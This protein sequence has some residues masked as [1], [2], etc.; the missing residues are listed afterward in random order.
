[1]R[2]SENGLFGTIIVADEH[3][4]RSVLLKNVREGCSFLDPSASIVSSELVGPGPI[5]GCAY[6]LSWLVPGLLFPTGSGLMIGL[7]AGA[8]AV[9]LL[10]N[11][12]DLDLTVVE[13]D[14][15][16]IQVAVTYFPLV[17]YYQNIGRLKIVQSDAASYVT[18]CVDKFDF[19]CADAY[20]GEQSMVD[21]FLPGMCKLCNSIYVNY[22]GALNDLQLSKTVEVM[23]DAQLQPEDLFCTSKLHVESPDVN[24]NWCIASHCPS[25]DVLDRF[26]PFAALD[27]DIPAVEWS[28]NMWSFMLSTSV[29]AQD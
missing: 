5:S 11:F 1:M 3:G 4:C 12:P 13:I 26:I 22:I 6:A 9:Q 29:A 15:V 17:D 27:D 8:G 20:T 19:G 25:M 24:A 7:G 10:Y 18:Q 2:Q 14:P 28:R 21:D 16:M 23:S